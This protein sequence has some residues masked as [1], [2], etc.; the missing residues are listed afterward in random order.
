MGNTIKPSKFCT[1]LR[2]SIKGFLKS[3]CI[4]KVGLPLKDRK[5]I[6]VV[7]AVYALFTLF[8]TVSIENKFKLSNTIYC[9]FYFHLFWEMN[10]SQIDI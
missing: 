6:F 8:S 4:F 1:S 7:V 2:S 10:F 9:G 5:W 3:Y